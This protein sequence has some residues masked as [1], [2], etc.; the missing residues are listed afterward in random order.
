[1]PIDPGA[2]GAKGDPM[3]TSWTSRD[4]M[5][6]ALGVGAGTGELAFTTENTQNVPQQVL[7]TMA[8]VLSGGAFGAIGKVGS[9]NPA[10]LVHGE[11]AIELH[12]PIPVAGTVNTTGE[13]AAIYDKGKGAL[14]VLKGES[15]DAATGELLFTTTFS[16]FIRGEGGWGGDRGPSGPRNEPPDGAAPDHVVT[17]QTTPDQALLYRLSGDRNPLHSDPSFAAMGGF[18]RPILHGLCTYGFAGRALLH[19]VC[20][21][22]PSRFRS[23]EG[24]FSS[25]V[26]PGE[27]LTTSIWRTGDGEAV[28]QTAGGDSRTV[29]D[30]GK[31]TFTP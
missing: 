15:V 26:F 30:A 22:D 2:V 24:R 1:M 29:L 7:P 5:L 18:D 20:D 25:P 21:G 9:F 6:Y 28:F 4:A 23:M 17:Y 12:G 19:S 11:Q 13:V 8:V 16:A 10:M 3:P 27:A 31:V 14:V